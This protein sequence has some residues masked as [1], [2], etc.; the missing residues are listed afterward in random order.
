MEEITLEKIDIIRERTGVSYAEAKE[1]LEANEGN[2]VEAL[3]YIEKNQDATKDSI[4]TSKEEFT[5]WI[6][7]VIRKGNVTRIKG[8]KR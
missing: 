2:V 8:K 3:V 7:E 6:K 4:Y 5:N 1:A